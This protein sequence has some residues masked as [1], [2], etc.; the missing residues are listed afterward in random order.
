MSNES[1]INNYYDEV[2]AFENDLKEYSD[3]LDTLKWIDTLGYNPGFE[4]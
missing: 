4:I 3:Y 2:S 1:M